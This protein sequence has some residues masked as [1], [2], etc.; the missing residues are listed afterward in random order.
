MER[1]RFL[2]QYPFQTFCHLKKYMFHEQLEISA[3]E[4]VLPTYSEEH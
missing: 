4:N 2:L 1:D 3:L